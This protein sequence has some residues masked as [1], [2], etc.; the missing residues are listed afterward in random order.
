MKF[1]LV[2]ISS[3]LLFLTGCVGKLESYNPLSEDELVEY[4]KNVIYNDLGDEVDVLINK[5][6]QEYLCD[7]NIDATCFGKH[8][9]P[10]TF[11]YYMTI[12]NKNNSEVTSDDVIFV[13]SY[14]EDGK[15]VERRFDYEEYSQS[16]YN[17]K[18][19]NEV[20]EILLGTNYII[21]YG[22]VYILE[23]NEDSSYI[24]D[25]FSYVLNIDYG[26]YEGNNLLDYN[27]FIIHNEELFNYVKS[28]EFDYNSFINES[29]NIRNSY[30]YT[31]EYLDIKTDDTYNYV[32][33]RYSNSGCKNNRNCSIL[34]G[35]NKMW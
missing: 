20:S 24:K 25:L 8:Y 29:V 17:A 3:L 31:H 13:D 22:D 4:V 32:F 27:I 21:K 19:A 28:S 33:F 5:K 6:S 16:H 12:T 7:A 14:K 23:N 26:M 2:I 11:V 15:I 10:D 30:G 35:I 1:R 9:I 18:F 34:Y